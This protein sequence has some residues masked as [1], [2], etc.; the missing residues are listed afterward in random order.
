MDQGA[1]CIAG[2]FVLDHVVGENQGFDSGVA[3][4]RFISVRG[5]CL[6][7]RSL[8][9]LRA[10]RGAKKKYCSLNFPEFVRLHSSEQGFD[11]F[12][13]CMT[14]MKINTSVGNGNSSIKYL[15]F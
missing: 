13:L 6:C 9:G 1:Y 3:R 14:V 8:K 5:C 11:Q 7:R 15:T 12:K 4:R 2:C 10:K